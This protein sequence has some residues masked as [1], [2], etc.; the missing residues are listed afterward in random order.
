[1]IHLGIRKL[2]Y[3]ESTQLLEGLLGRQLPPGDLLDEG[4]EPF[5]AHPTAWKGS[6]YSRKTRSISA[7]DS[8]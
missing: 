2:V 3:G 7:I 6:R 8:I 4:A 1:V 5:L